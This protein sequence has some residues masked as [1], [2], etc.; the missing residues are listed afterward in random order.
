M[1]G[2]EVLV[3]GRVHTIRATGGNVFVI[4]RQSFN[5]IQCV[6]SGKKD[7]AKLME[8]VPK[9]SVV[10]VT[11]TVAAA[12]VPIAS[13]SQQ[14]APHTVFPN[15]FCLSSPFPPA[16]QN[17]ELH[18]AKLFIVS[19]AAPQLPFQLEDASR[20]EVD[21]DESAVADS[22]RIRVLQD[23]RLD[24][25][26]IDLRTPANQAIMRISSGVCLLFREFLSA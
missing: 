4:L 22:G 17:F 9:E 11:A 21:D 10:D 20:P 14:V 18:V 24:N 26:W 12:P 19:K 2:K 1:E 8:G 3:R 25:R 23:T 7:V 6:Y 5:T 13:T 15:K 16:P